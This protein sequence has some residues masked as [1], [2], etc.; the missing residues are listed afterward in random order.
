MAEG[1]RLAVRSPP[2][3]VVVETTAG[4]DRVGGSQGKKRG[5]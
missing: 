5:A 1:W 2:A 4:G 3:K